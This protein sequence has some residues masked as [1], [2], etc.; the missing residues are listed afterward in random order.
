MV[1]SDAYTLRPLGMTTDTVAM[2][3]GRSKI[4]G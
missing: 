3:V 4:R 1:L 2:V